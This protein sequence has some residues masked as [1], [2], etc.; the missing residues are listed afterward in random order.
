[1]RW[2]DIEPAL[3]IEDELFGADAWSAGLFWSELA[4]HDNRQYFVL[5]S[6]ARLIGYAGLAVLDNEAYIQ[7]IAVQRKHWGSGL[8][9]VLLGSMLTIAEQ[10]G[11]QTV[12]LEVRADNERAH[13]LYER[14]GFTVIGVRRGYYQPSGADAHVMV[15]RS[16]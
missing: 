13:R 5:E 15:R 8:G 4:Q 14:F 16:A 12:G 3:A 9:T 7:T 6:S 2:W 10:R 1:M 11:A